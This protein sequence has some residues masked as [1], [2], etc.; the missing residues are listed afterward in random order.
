MLNEKVADLR[1]IL[2][3]SADDT[4]VLFHHYRWNRDQLEN[5]GYFENQDKIRREAGLATSNMNSIPL[6]GK[7][8]LCSICFETVNKEEASALTCNHYYCNAC[9]QGYVTEKVI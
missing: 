8:F 9:W 2:S 3:T 5:S 6:K 7:D 4:L 1:E